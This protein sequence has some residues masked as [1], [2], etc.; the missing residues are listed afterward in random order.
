MNILFKYTAIIVAASFV[1]STD[2]QQL[3]LRVVKIVPAEE[4]KLPEQA[5]FAVFLNKPL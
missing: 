2:A 5:A 3:Q 4:I 1:A